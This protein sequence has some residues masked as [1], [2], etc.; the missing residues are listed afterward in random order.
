MTKIGYGRISSGT[1]GDPT[2][3]TTGLSGIVTGTALAHKKGGTTLGA[4]GL[5]GVTVGVASRAVLGNYVSDIHDQASSVGGLG[6][7]LHSLAF[8]MLARANRSWPGPAMLLDVSGRS[9]NGFTSPAFA[10]VGARRMSLF[11][12]STGYAS[13]PGTA[14]QSPT[15]PRIEARV[16]LTYNSTTVI[17]GKW[18]G[19]AATSSY[20]LEMVNGQL[21]YSYSDGSTLA[22][23]TSDSLAVYNF[24]ERS[25]TV[26]AVEHLNNGT[27]GHTVIR[28]FF[29]V[30]NAK[31]WRQFGTDNA[32]VTTVNVAATTTPLTVGPGIGEIFWSRVLNATNGVLL[33]E[34]DATSLPSRSTQWGA[35]GDVWTLNNSVDSD[36]TATYATAPIGAGYLAVGGTSSYVVTNANDSGAGSLRDALSVSGRRITFTAGL[37]AVIGDITPLA[38]PSN[39]T[40]DGRGADITIKQVQG[41]STAAMLVSAVT[42][43]IIRN[44]KYVRDGVNT[45]LGDQLQISSAATVGW[46]DHCTFTGPPNDG[47]LD[48]T[49]VSDDITM[50]WCR[51]TGV[52]GNTVLDHDTACLWGAG[53]DTGTPALCDI[54]AHHNY[55]YACEDRT[56]YYRQVNAY[57]FNNVREDWGSAAHPTTNSTKIGCGSRVRAEYDWFIPGAYTG[58]CFAISTGGGACDVTRPPCLLTANNDYGGRAT[59]ADQNTGSVNPVTIGCIPDALTTANRDRVR[60]YAGWNDVP[61]SGSTNPALVQTG[62][63]ADWGLSLNSDVIVDN[64]TLTI[65]LADGGSVA[66]S[67]SATGSPAADLQL[68]TSSGSN[69]GRMV[70]LMTAAGKFRAVLGDNIFESD[71]VP[72]DTTI[73]MDFDDTEVLAY[74]NGV[75]MTLLTAGSIPVSLDIIPSRTGDGSTNSTAVLLTGLAVTDSRLTTDEREFVTT[76]LQG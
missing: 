64:T 67:V 51:F 61:L 57:D 9:R 19:V 27:S 59:D 38:L 34:F 25:D 36:P 8:K 41:N 21:K 1:I 12:G 16:R 62:D 35:L 50:S 65:T 24:A 40:I 20:K 18:T 70:I 48:I 72:G 46:V 53:S 73:L 37:T 31:T 30:D 76:V 32:L 10:W 13:A 66:A 69:T 52:R 2:V 60:N 22:S 28:F 39:T 33:S 49:Q 4:Q 11:G 17:L 63:V 75:P 47:C 26:V 44:L 6:G 15:Q 74:A 3:P 55:W 5:S 58:K 23:A 45:S 43:F 56:P 42:N 29:S 68:I 7:G 54:T 14:L 71:I